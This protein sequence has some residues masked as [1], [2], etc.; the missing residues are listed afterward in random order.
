MAL[1]KKCSRLARCLTSVLICCSILLV[2]AVTRL[3]H[4]RSGRSFVESQQEI[5][6][7]Q[8]R[9]RRDRDIQSTTIEGYLYEDVKRGADG[10]LIMAF[11]FPQYHFAP[12]NAMQM[13]TYATKTTS[14]NDLYTDW[15][16][17]KAHNG[18]RSFT[19]KRY[20][21]LA[22]PSVFDTQDELAHTWGVGVFIFYHYWLDNSMVLNLPVDVYL[23]KKRKTKF[24]LC[25]DNESGFLGKQLYDSPEKHAYQLLR[26]FLSENYLTD[27]NGRKPFLIYL[28]A[29]LD[30][31]YLN[32]LIRFL[33]THGVLVTIGHNY[34]SYKNNWE[35]P[36]W[37]EIASEFGPHA[38][39]GPQ[40]ANLYEYVVRNPD[41]DIS[42]SSPAF[43]QYWQGAITS[44]DSRPRCYSGRT[45]Q[46]QCKGDATNG[47]VSPEGF[48]ALLRQIKANFHPMN[49]DRVITIFAWNEWAEG[50]ALEESEEFGLQFLE[51]LV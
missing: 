5:M 22:N 36:E 18:S 7:R 10:S 32:R 3:S 28:T 37:S 25:W 12:E 42:W 48:G 16:V 15:D 23:T 11:Y 4:D 44:W 17:V 45:H 14:G 24:L 9:L 30:V 31:V 19:P 6:A 43:K 51:K 50:A 40:R 13:R 1:A 49:K 33:E 21:N 29:K 38:D 27:V 26:Y 46:T 34:Q 39:G 35:L 20:Y 2:S 8:S 41:N 47:Q